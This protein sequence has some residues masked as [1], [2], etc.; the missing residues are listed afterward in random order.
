MIYITKLDNKVNIMLLIYE[1]MNDLYIL[2][3]FVSIIN[4]YLLV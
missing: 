1:R 4:Y 3:L 2:L